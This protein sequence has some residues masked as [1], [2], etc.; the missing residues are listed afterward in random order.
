MGGQIEIYKV[1]AFTNHKEEGNP[2][3]VVLNAEQLGEI[4]MQAIARIPDCSHTA[5]LS[6][7][8]T[9]NSDVRIRFFTSSGEL[10]NCAHATIACHVLRADLL[11]L[12]QNI[13]LKQQ[14]Q[15][16]IQDVEIR[17]DKGDIE[18]FFKQNEILFSEPEQTV[19]NELLSFLKLTNSDID[20]RYPIILASPA[21]NRFLIGV[22]SIHTLQRLSPD[23]E[24]LKR[25]CEQANSIG[26]FAFAVED[27]VSPLQ[28][29][30]RMFAPVIGVDEDIINGNSSGCLGAYLL[31]LNGSDSLS[32]SIKQGMTH[33]RPGTVLVYARRAD[34][35][36]E[37]QVGG[38]AT[39]ISRSYINLSSLN[40]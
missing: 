10:K 7:S 26:C 35:I 6:K 2:T 31:Q 11:A 33:H 1:A 5:F 22:N 28:A 16:G 39:I 37:T 38:T 34:N 21:V 13:T 25:L 14:T 9:G 20:E 3:G 23:F 29:S 4:E 40:P 18:V 12:T 27:T 36:I 19:V 17:Y 32:I 24:G 15:A 8:N 30:A